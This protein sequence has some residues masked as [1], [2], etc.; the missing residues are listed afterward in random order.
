MSE[1]TDAKLNPAAQAAAATEPTLAKDE[2]EKVTSKSVEES[3]TTTDKVAEAAAQAGETAKENVSAAKDNIFSMFGGGAKKEKKV[4][5]DDANEAS[6]SSKK[7][8]DEV[9]GSLGQDGPVIDE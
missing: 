9:R 1:N 5:D 4:D 8:N 6:G 3:K 7:N 2:T